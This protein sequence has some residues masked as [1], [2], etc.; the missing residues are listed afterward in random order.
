MRHSLHRGYAQ[1]ALHRR[2]SVPCR[3]LAGVAA[4]P[5]HGSMY[6]HVLLTASG[7]YCLR[8]MR[9]LQCSSHATSPATTLQLYGA[10]QHVPTRTAH[11]MY[12]SQ[13]T[14][15]TAYVL[16]T[17]ANWMRRLLGSRLVVMSTFGSDSPACAYSSSTCV[18]WTCGHA[19]GMAQGLVYA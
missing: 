12:C 3:L 10:R 19:D 14:A 8:T 15:C 13:H 5:A 9:K 11:S 16:P 17:F 4:H 7:L 1:S 6:P 18:L 2:L